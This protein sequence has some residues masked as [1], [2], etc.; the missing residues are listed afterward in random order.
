MIDKKFTI[1]ANFYRYVDTASAVENVIDWL[2]A[3]VGPTKFGPVEVNWYHEDGLVPNFETLE[4]LYQQATNDLG[5]KVFFRFWR[6]TNWQ[7]F[8]AEEPTGNYD[9]PILKVTVE[10]DDSILALQCKLACF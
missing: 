1:S 2:R 6:G 10:L 7:V 8:V 5:D 4:S 9:D 3:E